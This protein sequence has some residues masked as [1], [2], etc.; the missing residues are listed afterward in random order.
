MNLSEKP[1]TPWLAAILS[2]FTVP[3]GQVYAGHF[4]RS[5][6]IWIVGQILLTAVL[7]LA[8]ATSLGRVAAILV[9]LCPVLYQVFQAVDAFRLA[10]RNRHSPRRNYQRWWVYI[11]VGI[12]FLGANGVAMFV[13]RTFIVEPFVIPSGSMS[14]TI[15]PGDYMLVEKY[16]VRPK[17]LRP[18]DLVVFRSEGPD[19]PFFVM[20]LV[21]LPGDVVEIKRGQVWVNGLAWQDD[22]AV[23]GGPLPSNPGL[24]IAPPPSTWG[25][26]NYGPITV[27]QDSFFVLG[28]NRRNSRDSRFLGS[29]PFSSLHGKARVIY[30]SRERS[31]PNPQDKSPYTLARIRWE[32]IG[33]RLD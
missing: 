28:D 5:V 26:E 3:L 22:H 6:V 12:L 8:V 29:I 13:V 14:P 11:L 1:R 16:D 25:F 21:G 31:F 2:L 15:E 27:P 19:S 7:F 23:F 10:Q 20:R 24:L 33:S 17:N 9:L 30:W 4:Q 32:R 18:N